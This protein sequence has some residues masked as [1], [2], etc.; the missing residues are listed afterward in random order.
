MAD[1]EV[2]V[3]ATPEKVPDLPGVRR[4]AR[5][6]QAVEAGGFDL[7]AIALPPAMHATAA[8]AALE[9]GLHVLVEK[10]L[11][12]SLADADRIAEAAQR[13]RRVAAVNYMMRFNP[14]VEAL[15]AWCRSGAFGRLRRVVVEN[16]AQDQTLAPDHWFWDRAQSGGIL[17]EHS[18]HFIDLV[19]GCTPGMPVRVQG[20]A[21]RRPD[22]REDR[23]LMNVL[24]DSGLAM[25]QY[26]AFS[27]PTFFEETTLR[28]VFD[29]A[30]L[31]W[32][33]WIPL[34]GSVRALTT[35]EG[36]AALPLLPR[37]TETARTF[38]P[39]R[40]ALRSGGVAY[41]PTA[42]VTGTF[43][44]TVSKSEAYADAVRA[45]LYDVRAAIETPGH[46]L[47]AGLEE[48][49]SSLEI[50]LAATAEGLPVV[51]AP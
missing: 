9:A 33:G 47:R 5:W 15:H 14:I 2:V 17:V 20:A 11:A 28:F 1:V 3:I 51:E 43:G 27:R 35:D 37:F 29:L 48:A 42:D 13:T 23:V 40:P 45:L 10:P 38:L 7:A 41:T 4:F 34:Q 36:E 12:T 6:E 31:R 46:R 22:G 19:H 39:A 50:A 25:T 49:R 32:E 18:V 21:M 30:E 8:V 16:Y 44:L 24:Y 26:H